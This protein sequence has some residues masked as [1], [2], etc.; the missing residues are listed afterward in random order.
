MTGGD[1]VLRVKP[2]ATCKYEATFIVRELDASGAAI[3]NG[4][5]MMR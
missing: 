3:T 1:T 2:D 5:A 4:S